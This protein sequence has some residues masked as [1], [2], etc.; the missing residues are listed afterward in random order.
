[1]KNLK[2]GEA[3]GNTC[4]ANRKHVLSEPETRAQRTGNVWLGTGNTWFQGF[5]SGLRLE[6]RAHT[7]SL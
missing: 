6:A 1:M 2:H 5:T 7:F 3:A 4:S